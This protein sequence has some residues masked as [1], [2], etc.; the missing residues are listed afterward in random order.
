MVSREHMSDFSTEAGLG[1]AYLETYYPSQ[2]DEEAFQAALIAVEEHFGS[3]QGGALDVADFSTR[4]GLAHEVIENASILY[5]LSRIAEVL[6]TDWAG[7][8]ISV[9]DIGG[10][11]TIYQHIPVSLV[12]D[13]IIHAEPLEEN[14]VEVLKY[15]RQEKEAY[16]WGAYFRV[17]KSLLERSKLFPKLSQ[18]LVE[19]M[20][21]IPRDTDLSIETA[22]RVAMADLI[23]GRVIPCD[24]FQSNLELSPGTELARAEREVGMTAGASLVE[25]NFLLESATDSIEQWN[26]G[27]DNLT[28]K[29]APG[30]FLSMMAI[31]NA[32]WYR[33][34][35]EK[36]PAVPVNESFL[37]QEL[38]RRSFSL[39][40]VRV[41]TG[42]DH[43]TFGYDGMV[44]VLAQKNVS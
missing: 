25:S 15:L 37:R 44:F 31:R 39:S 41:L 18:K 13:T 20:D 43:E 42:S 23:A 2:F 6:A 35:E 32:R 36:I 16:D 26:V 21:T 8:R 34:G 19:M 10:G 40:H 14:R 27:L 17:T 33:S 30:G 7:R 1:R 3:E 9:L 38:E 4:Y 22:W 5:H 11:P 12:A 24:A 28:A 29:V